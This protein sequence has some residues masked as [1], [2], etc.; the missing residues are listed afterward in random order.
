M[1]IVIFTFTQMLLALFVNAQERKLKTIQ[2]SM[3]ELMMFEVKLNPSDTIFNNVNFDHLPVKGY[4]FFTAV[5]GKAF[6]TIEQRDSILQKI[7]DLF[8]E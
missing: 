5:P 8:Y 3:M 4:P 7:D 2:P 6:Y 1:K